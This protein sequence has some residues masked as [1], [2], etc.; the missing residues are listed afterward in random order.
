MQRAEA[1]WFIVA[2]SEENL[3]PLKTL[4]EREK[5]SV[6]A[7][8]GI[9]SPQGQQRKSKSALLMNCTLGHLYLIT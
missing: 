7:K 9:Q 6:Q 5:R 3:N 2:V 1:F 4:Y 8:E